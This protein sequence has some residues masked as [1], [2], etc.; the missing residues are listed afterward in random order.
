MLVILRTGRVEEHLSISSN[1]LHTEPLNWL[2]SICCSMMQ[3]VSWRLHSINDI[4]FVWEFLPEI[5]NH[6][7][8]HNYHHNNI[9]YLSY[10]TQQF[11]CNLLK[12]L[13][14]LDLKIIEYKTYMKDKNKYNLNKSALVPN[15]FLYSFRSFL[16]LCVRHKQRKQLLKLGCPESGISYLDVV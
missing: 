2:N 14:Q 12:L 15:A 8:P 5:K 11:H 9:R 16:S 13:L 1:T 10:N 4:W 6:H 7:N 3:I